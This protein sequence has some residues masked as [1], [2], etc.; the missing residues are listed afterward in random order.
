MILRN[1]AACF[2]KDND[3]IEARTSNEEDARLQA[4]DDFGN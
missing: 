4:E 2:Q 3:I 1:F